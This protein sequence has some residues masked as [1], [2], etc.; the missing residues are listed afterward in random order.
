MLSQ[1]Y[2]FVIGHHLS[3]FENALL[4]AFSATQCEAARPLRDLSR[5]FQNALSFQLF[6]LKFRFR[7]SLAQWVFLVQLLYVCILVLEVGDQLV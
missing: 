7:K 6:P 3:F 1:L 2:V 5:G 4:I